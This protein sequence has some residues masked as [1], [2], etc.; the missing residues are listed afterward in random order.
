MKVLLFGAGENARRFIRLNP[1]AEK[2]EIVG[3]VDNDSARWGEKF[4]QLYT[5]EAPTVIMSKEWE[6]I[7]VT[8]ASF[9]VI[10]EQLMTEY[11]VEKKQIIRSSDLIVPDKANLGSIRVSCAS[12]ECCDIN[13]IVPDQV[14]PGNQLEEFYFRGDHRDVSKWWHYFE[15]YHT[16]FQKFIGKDVKILE[17]GVCMGGSLQMWKDYFGEKA[18]IVGIDINPYCKTLEEENIHICI[19]SQADRDFLLSVSEQWGPFDIILDDGSH[20]SSHQILTFET[21]FPLLRENGVFICEDCHCAYSPGYG[22]GYKKKDTFIEYSKNFVDCVNGQFVDWDKIQE[23]PFYSDYV[24]A[25]HYYDSMVVVEKR[26]RGY[27][28]FSEHNQ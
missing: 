16:F 2:I 27:S 25:C 28:F 24:K 26:Y 15:V 14:V 13:E 4:E 18:A 17:I 19:G 6:K 1:A 21:L 7:A 3:V 12:D 22:G 23:L 10:K 20:E 8:P 5:I 11:G 9:T